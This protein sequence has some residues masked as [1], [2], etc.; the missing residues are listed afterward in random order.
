MGSDRLH[1]RAARQR[2]E[3]EAHTALVTPYEERHIWLAQGLDFHNSDMAASELCRVPDDIN[4]RPRGGR[5]SLDLR[6]AADGTTTYTSHAQHVHFILH[7]VM[8]EKQQWIEKLGIPGVMV[9]YDG[10]ARYG[11]G[12]CF[13]DVSLHAPHPEFPD[14]TQCPQT[15]DNWENGVDAT[16]FGLFRMGYPYIELPL[17]ET[18][19]HRYHTELV[20]ESIDIKSSSLREQLHPDVRTKLSRYERYTID[21]LA[22][23]QAEHRRDVDARLARRPGAGADVPEDL[24]GLQTGAPADTYGDYVLNRGD[25]GA[26][27]WGRT[28]RIYYRSLGRHFDAPVALLKA[29]WNRT[30]SAPSDLGTVTP[31]CKCFCHFG[32][33]TFKH[34]YRIMRFEKGWQRDG[35]DRYAYWTTNASVSLTSKY[36]LYRWFTYPNRNDFQPWANSLAYAVRK[37][38]QDLDIEDGTYHVI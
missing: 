16:K 30:R 27:F 24:E 6:T 29:G 37:T 33:S 17:T 11:R 9:I 1:R 7:P 2:R 15:G 8:T 18:L 36:W 23:M 19:H 31:T 22:A 35:D 21:E 20:E 3:S 34:N 38:N 28:M 5:G 10:H 32:C 12:P 25:S 4:S 13:G 26:R 14:I